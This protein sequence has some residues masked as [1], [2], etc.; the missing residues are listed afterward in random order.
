MSKPEPPDSLLDAGR[1]M[2]SE[3]VGE[4]DLRAD[5]LR[6]LRFACTALDLA[7]EFEAA[8]REAGS[9]WSSKGSMGQEVE[10]PLIG[11]ADKQRKACDAFLKRLNLPDEADT[12]EA[13]STAARA[14]ANAR[15]SRRGA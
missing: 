7:H 9:P 5:E 1:V 14:A 15:W 8:W 3:I 13:R 6:T 12:P 10:H 2:W 4:Y 11:S